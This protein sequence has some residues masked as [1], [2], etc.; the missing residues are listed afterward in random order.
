M[1]IELSEK[2][3]L[4]GCVKNDRKSQ[5]SLYRL[6]A[7]E[8]YRICLA[9]EPDRDDAKDILQQGFLKVF[10]SI[11]N[12]NGSGSLKGWVRRIISNTAIDYY[13]RKRAG[14]YTISL[15]EL[16][17]YA[18]PAGDEK[19]PQVGEDLLREVERLPEGARL[20]F[21]LYAIEG[22]G[23]REIADKLGI[24]E[25][26]SKSQLNRAR[27]ILKERLKQII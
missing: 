11:R 2:T 24:T 26:T 7:G 5:E 6:Y 17:D 10:R 3:L 25:G 18:E 15:D 21:N 20:V 9:Y 27:R 8:M 19:D 22:Y 14:G 16:N 12:Y 13:R 4:E 1:K 23:H